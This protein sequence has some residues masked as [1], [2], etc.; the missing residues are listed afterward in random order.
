MFTRSLHFKVTAWY[1]MA[2]AAILFIFSTIVYQNFK[3]SLIENLDNLLKSKAESIDDLI[4]SHITDKLAGALSP[5]FLKSVKSVVQEERDDDNAFVQILGSHGEMLDY[6]NKYTAQVIPSV[7]INSSLLKGDIQIKNVKSPL[8]GNSYEKLRV[9]T[10]PILRNG[11]IAYIIQVEEYLR[12]VYLTLHKL[13]TVLYLF[14]PLALFFAVLIGLFLTKVA[15]N[16]VD[17]IARTM[18]HITTENLQE[19]I[20]IPNADNEI[21]ILADTFN[22]MLTRLEKAFSTQK[23]FIQDISHELRTPLTAMRGKQEVALKKE[24]TLKEYESVL[25]VNLEE[26]DKMSHLVEDLLVLIKIEAQG[27]APKVVSID[28]AVLI[29]RVLNGIMI[30]AQKKHIAI[31]SLLPEG[32]TVKGNDSQISRVVLNILDNAI[33]Y[34]P[35]NGQIEIKLL[36]EDSLAKILITNTGPGIAPQELSRIFDRFYRADQSRNSPGFGLG[37]S[38]AQSIITAHQGTIEVESQLANQTIFTVTL[39]L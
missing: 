16:P 35:I 10:M 5:E 26:I 32:I 4:D 19:R 30:L 7:V 3:Y 1:T 36:K 37:L 6:S 8:I 24:R 20:Q 34:T 2:F 17:R 14:L 27:A 12:P 25:E 15:L 39:P 28:L 13:K 31:N 29:K 9:L 33:K 18:C 23:Q 38:I 11:K 22:G 21:K